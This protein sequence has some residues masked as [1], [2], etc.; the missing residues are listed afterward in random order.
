LQ[1]SM[2]IEE[3]LINDKLINNKLIDSLFRIMY[4]FREITRPWI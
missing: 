4:N 3:S 1:A 2:H